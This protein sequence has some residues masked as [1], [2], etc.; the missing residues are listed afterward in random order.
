MID[1]GAPALASEGLRSDAS[2]RMTL[3]SLPA[4]SCSIAQSGASLHS[5]STRNLT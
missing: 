1:S 3:H 5:L 4:E 2:I